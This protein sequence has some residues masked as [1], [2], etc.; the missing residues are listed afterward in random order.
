MTA[1]AITGGFGLENLIRTQ[2]QPRAPGPGE[3]RLRM[4][5]AA[6]NYRDLGVI[7]GRYNPDFVLPLV[8]FSDGV[9]VIEEIGA[10]VTGWRVGDRAATMFFPDW[11]GGRPEAA[12][13]ANMRGGPLE[14]ALQRSLTVPAQAVAPVPA[15]LTDVEAAT[16]PCA[17][18]TAWRALVTEGGVKAGDRVLIHGTGG[19]ALFALQFAR[20]FG[21]EV[22]ITS[23]SNEKLA[24]ARAAGTTLG[25][26]Y[27]TSP[28]IAKQVLAAT[29]G[30]GADIVVETAGGQTLAQS[31]D[32][33]ATGGMVVVIGMVGGHTAEIPLRPLL[34]KNVRL[35][36]VSVGNRQDFLAMSRAI[37]SHGLR[38]MID[39][40]FPF[41]NA[42]DALAYL[43]S[44][45][46]FG[47]VVIEF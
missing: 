3:V 4:T 44:G 1:F 42:P 8:P 17:A 34:F 29:D 6:L 22:I 46:H 12:L 41:E 32:A 18:L 35:H 25:I 10:N 27:V 23:K 47:K 37:D 20:L 38:P 5:A 30:H 7:A 16:L 11:Q 24:R 39:R 15:T 31:I 28:E 26:N 14:G 13:L 21:A 43:K 19:V 33:A 36:G 9:G 45:Q 40:V 2:P